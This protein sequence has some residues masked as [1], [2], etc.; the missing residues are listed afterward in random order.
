MTPGERNHSPLPRARTLAEFLAIAAHPAFRL[1]VEAAASGRSHDP[2]TLPARLAAAGA[3]SPSPTPE[4]RGD[5][6]L[7]QIRE[8]EGR[9]LVAA[10]GARVA[11]RIATPALFSAPVPPALLAA[12]ASLAAGPS[13]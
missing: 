3:P 12:L 13:P 2:D 6:E 10:F 9:R 1:G 7:A 4:G 11:W 5:L 8:E